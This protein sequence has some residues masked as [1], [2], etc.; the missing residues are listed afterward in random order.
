MEVEKYNTIDEI[1]PYSCKTNNLVNNDYHGKVNSALAK[2]PIRTKPFT[3][4]NYSSTKFI[5]NVSQ[6][7]PPIEKISKLKFKF[8]Y[9]DGRLVDFKSMSLSFSIGFSILSNEQYNNKMVRVPY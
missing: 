5:M 3:S 1:A 8:R 9:H 7:E 6:Y 4:E 2:I